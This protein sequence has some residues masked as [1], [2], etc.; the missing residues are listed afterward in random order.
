MLLPY[1]HAPR[2]AET[3]QNLRKRYEPKLNPSF[4]QRCS[5]GQR[6]WQTGVDPL[7]DIELL[8]DTIENVQV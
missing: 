4:T 6:G 2:S 7:Y 3:D 8:L 5:G 1:Y